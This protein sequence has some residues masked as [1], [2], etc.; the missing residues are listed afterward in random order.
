MSAWKNI[1]ILREYLQFYVYEWYL[2]Y[3]LGSW[4]CG[5]KVACAKMTN[6]IHECCYSHANRVCNT[7]WVRY[8][9]L[10][11]QPT[12]SL[13]DERFKA[14]L[15][16][17]I[18]APVTSMT[19]SAPRIP[20]VIITVSEASTLHIHVSLLAGPE[21][22]IICTLGKN[23]QNGSEGTVSTVLALEFWEKAS[24]CVTLTL[25]GL[26]FRSFLWSF[27]ASATAPCV[28]NSTNACLPP[29]K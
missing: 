25:T 10:Q 20:S 21:S 7:H 12:V 11:L 9:H 15:I 13:Y 3:L 18:G 14:C 28:V 5:L 16:I 2:R 4:H 26:F 27:R 24:L 22:R 17:S 23:L 19:I 8:L 1:N 6:V 29:I